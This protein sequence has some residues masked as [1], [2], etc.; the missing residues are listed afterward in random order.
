M[1]DIPLLE[2]RVLNGVIQEMVPPDEFVG[3]SILGSPIGDIN[4]T[5]EYDV[6]VENRGA[7]VVFNVPNAEARILD[8]GKMERLQGGY[9]YIRDKKIFNATT[10]RWLRAAGENE[11]SRANAERY[12]M[13]EVETMRLR[14]MRGEEIATWNMFMGEWTYTVQ[15]GATVKVTYHIPK[16][17]RRALGTQA[18][19]TA[20][21]I[22]GFGT[23]G[24]D[25]TSDGDDAD[26][27]WGGT[28]DKVISNI[29]T[30]KRVVSRT[31]GGNI[32]RAYANSVTLNKFYELPEVL[33]YLNDSQK[34]R[35]T[36]DR[37]IPRF[38]TID[39]IEYDG[40]Y[41]SGD[42]YLDDTEDIEGTSSVYKP[43]I[44][45]G[46]FIFMTDAVSAGPLWEM[47]HGPSADNDAP[48]GHTGPFTKTWTDPDPSGL[49]YL[50]EI[51][52]MPILYQPRGILIAYTGIDK[53]AP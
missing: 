27:R 10:L 16:R 39:W 44:P 45:D 29:N 52:F 23:A 15:T 14:H 37:V 35:F 1:P 24:T 53:R 47:R 31:F 12:V 7:E 21:N 50:M 43:F 30:W 51:N 9:A 42:G 13:R 4:P 49:Q 22:P 41:I 28:N 19:I 48:T 46:V 11:V 34:G 6:L 38:M 32:T 2:P 40:G 26:D 20:E 33:Q 8:H 18:Q 3:L 5:W 25:Y 17:N 36:T